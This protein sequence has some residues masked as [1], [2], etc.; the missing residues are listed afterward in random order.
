MGIFDVIENISLI[1][2]LQGDLMQSWSSIAYYFALL[3]L[4]SLILAILYLIFNWIFLL[5]IKKPI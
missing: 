4:G 1:R 3:K 5:F 2:L